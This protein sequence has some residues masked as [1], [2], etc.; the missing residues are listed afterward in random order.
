LWCEHPGHWH[1]WSAATY[2]IDQT[3]EWLVRI[4]PYANL[5]LTVLRSAVP[6]AAS[7][8]GV[9]MTGEQ[10]KHA[11]SELQ[12]MTTL[13]NELPRLDPVTPPGIPATA[14]HP[15]APAQGEAMRA[16]RTAIFQHDPNKAFGDMRRVLT[17]AGDYLWICP[18]HYG[19]YDPGLPSIPGS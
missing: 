17:A 6:I 4:S 9:A 15:V 5:V 11:R 12:L 16:V 2:N 13:S 10:L 14:S 7:A 19:I 8:A 18:E 3:R 1:P